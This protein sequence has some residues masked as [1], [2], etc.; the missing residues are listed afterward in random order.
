MTEGDLYKER[1]RMKFIDGIARQYHS[2]MLSQR[3]Y[4]EST[5]STIATW[6]NAV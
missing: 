3:S 2:L 4:M 6:R 1:D 5:I